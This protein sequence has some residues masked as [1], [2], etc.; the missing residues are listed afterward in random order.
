MS[1]EESWNSF[2]QQS[3]LEEYLENSHAYWH[4]YY[5]EELRMHVESLRNY[6]GDE[7]PEDVQRAFVE[8]HGWRDLVLENLQS[9]DSKKLISKIKEQFRDYLSF[10]EPFS[11]PYREEEKGYIH[12]KT[13]GPSATAAL[14]KSE[15]FKAL[16]NF[17]GYN[18]SRTSGSKLT[19]E[20]EWPE[21][22]EGV[23]G[24]GYHIIYDRQIPG[25]P[26]GYTVLD[27]IKDHG[28]RPKQQEG[29][30][31]YPNRV[32]MFFY[33]PCKTQ[34][35]LDKLR[36]DSKELGCT[37]YVWNSGNIKII[38]FRVPQEITWYRDPV[39]DGPAYFTYNS[40]PAGC[41]GKIIEIPR[42]D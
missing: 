39:M 10:S 26:E 21:V 13:S 34:E 5:G 18:I 8:S 2:K 42:Q 6:F 11:F 9:H 12:I 7:I 38:K 31:F 35:A 16:V 28:L 30:R 15:K 36:E 14:A 41:I 22:A 32:Y 29:G 19:L 23:G 24:W 27:S 4:P 20:P 40:I 3:I 37:D 17:F 25:A 1:W 33:G